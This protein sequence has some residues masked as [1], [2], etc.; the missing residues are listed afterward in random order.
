MSVAPYIYKHCKIWQKILLISEIG[1][2]FVV[3]VLVLCIKFL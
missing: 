2:H 1:R 3:V